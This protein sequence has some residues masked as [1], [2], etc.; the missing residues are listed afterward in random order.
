MIK[1]VLL[2]FGAYVTIMLIFAGFYKNVYNKSP[3]CFL[4]KEQV[5]SQRLTNRINELK[6]ELRNL[7]S[8]RSS[9]YNYP[10]I[11]DKFQATNLEKIESIRALDIS[12]NIVAERYYFATFRL[13][14]LNFHFK[15]YN[16]TK[17]LEYYLVIDDEKFIG[18][19]S[20]EFVNYEQIIPEFKV[21]TLS[22]LE[23][24]RLIKRIAKNIAAESTIIDKNIEI[25]IAEKENEL[26]NLVSDNNHWNYADFTYF[27]ISTI[28]GG[29]YGDI[30]PNCSKVRYYVIAEY[31]ICGFLIIVLLNVI[32]KDRKK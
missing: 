32:L 19:N 4:I 27:S 23:N 24:N 7:N 31:L 8:Q 25:R 28:F 9:F 3:E 17:R 22:D 16:Y 26:E 21:V 15:F 10:E 2:F 29:G 18:A 1:R 13:D 20:G 30:V 14:S 12:D 5:D 6:T 11:W